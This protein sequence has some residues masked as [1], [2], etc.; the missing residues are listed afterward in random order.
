[1]ERLE[2]E[3]DERNCDRKSEAAI[4]ARLI[5]LRDSQKK[6]HFERAAALAKLAKEGQ[7]KRKE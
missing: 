7:L 4:K 1:L 6:E 5:R 3:G 2:R